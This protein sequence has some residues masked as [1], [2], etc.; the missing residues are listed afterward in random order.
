M[1]KILE[2]EYKIL[3]RREILPE[4]NKSKREAAMDETKEKKSKEK[5]VFYCSVCHQKTKLRCSRCKSVNY[6]YGD[7]FSS[8]LHIIIFFKESHSWHIML[9]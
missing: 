3:K 7:S 5:K 8:N 9:I 2:E 1:E 6:W 4:Y